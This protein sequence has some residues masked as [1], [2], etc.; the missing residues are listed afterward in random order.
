MTEQEHSRQEL[1]GRYIYAVTR[2]LPKKQRG[3]VAKELESIISDMLEERCGPI[4]PTEHDLRVVLTEL[5]TP[6]ELARKYGLSDRHIRTI[7][8][9]EGIRKSS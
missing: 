9:E 6:S 4:T 8:Q 1:T 3:D 7:L 2:R 5:G